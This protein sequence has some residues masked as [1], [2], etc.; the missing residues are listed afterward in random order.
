MSIKKVVE[1][2]DRPRSF[3]KEAFSF[4]QILEISL[5]FWSAA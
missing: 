3:S 2:K 4:A 1:G 5:V